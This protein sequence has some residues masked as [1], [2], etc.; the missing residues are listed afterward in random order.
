[1]RCLNSGCYTDGLPLNTKLC[2]NCGAYLP[3]LTRDLLASGRKLHGN[4]YQINY[5]LGRGGFGVTYQ[6]YHKSLQK[7]VA[8]KEYYPQN[9]AFRHPT[10]GGFTIPKNQQEI[11]QR[12][13]QRFLREGQ[14]LAKL[15]HPHVVRVKDLFE[16]NDTA[17]LVMELV[18]GK[19]LRTELDS[20]PQKKFSPEKIAEIISPLVLALS[21]VHQQGIF[22]LDI[23]PDNILLTPE[24]RLVLI[25]FGSAKQTFGTSMSTSSTRTFTEAYAAP[26]V[27][28]G[29]EVG[30]ESDIFEVGMMVYE[31]L[32]GQLPPNALQRLSKQKGWQPE[33]LE[34][35]WQELVMS[36]LVFEQEGRPGNIQ[37][38][39]KIQFKS[40][41]SK[42]R[43]EELETNIQELET[44][45]QELETNIQESETNIQESETNI[46]ESETSIQESE[47]KI[48]Q[49]I[50]FLKDLGNR[51]EKLEETSPFPT[52][53]LK[54]LPLPPKER[55]PKETSEKK[56][57]FPKGV[58]PDKFSFEVIKVNSQGQEISR[59]RQEAEFFREYLDEKVV[60]EMVYIPGGNFLMGSP[61]DEFERES[62]ENLQH[63]VTLQPFFISKYPITQ[64]QYQAIMGNNPSRFKGG[65][66]PVE[67]VSWDEATNF[68]KKLRKKTGKIY[69]LPSESQWE[70]ACRAGTT[71]SF[72]FGETIT[73]ELVNYDGNYPYGNAPQGKFLKQT[74]AL[75]RFPPNAFGLYDMH[76]NVWEW[77]Q[78]LW[79]NN[80]NGAP[81]DGT[82]W[83]IWGQSKYRLHRVIRGGSWVNYSRDC[84]CARRSCSSGDRFSINRGFRVVLP[85]RF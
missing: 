66:R 50:N 45:I 85:V 30:V 35:P 63:K 71:T 24:G 58:I 84:R 54:P 42:V 12:G 46:Q 16:E 5:A 40:Q 74:T 33:D 34:S 65:S 26:E 72:Y 51:S 22:H 38:W 62:D 75:G 56:S 23:K 17:Y 39:W 68:R 55:M 19:T 53:P 7:T 83:E 9:H 21:A 64:N 14:I 52:K 8:I 47:T 76:G 60:L 61:K 37:E 31:M 73:P 59:R 3:S 81:T 82:A 11:F 41:K 1:M 77:C 32:T 44:S 18:T 79:H 49:F 25:D 67:S 20:Q 2:P 27:I 28:G 69:R 80:Y 57:P 29:G 15:D 48:S 10:T 78:D 70:Y 13:L 43:S 36:A 6:G 4:K